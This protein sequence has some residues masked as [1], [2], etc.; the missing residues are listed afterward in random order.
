MNE[1][2]PP[3][4]QFQIEMIQILRWILAG[5]LGEAFQ[6]IALYAKPLLGVLILVFVAWGLGLAILMLFEAMS[7]LIN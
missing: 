3:Y 5:R 1:A 2:I 6:L 4:I 7:Q